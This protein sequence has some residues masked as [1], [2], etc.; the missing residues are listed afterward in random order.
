MNSTALIIIHLLQHNEQF[1]VNWYLYKNG[2]RYSV[3]EYIKIIAPG[4]IY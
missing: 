1:C 4:G 3:E 2:K